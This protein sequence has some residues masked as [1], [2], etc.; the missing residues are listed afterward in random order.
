MDIF[1]DLVVSKDPQ[2]P[3]HQ[4][5]PQWGLGTVFVAPVIFPHQADGLHL[6][7][8]AISAQRFRI[9]NSWCCCTL[10]RQNIFVVGLHQASCSGSDC[11]RSCTPPSRQNLCIDI[12][13]CTML[14][15]CPGTLGH[16]G[17][18]Q[19]Q[20]LGS[21]IA[22][23]IFDL[24]VVQICFVQKGSMDCVPQMGLQC[25]TFTQSHQFGQVV[26][27]RF[28]VFDFAG[29]IIPARIFRHRPTWFHTTWEK[30]SLSESWWSGDYYI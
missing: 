25:P 8:L 26:A 21:I 1:C 13:R 16:N 20:G 2:E 5:T 10:Q 29:V 23:T 6:Q 27:W 9:W 24:H 17:P 14:A 3:V 30:E 4:V 19:M 18:W 28:D 12:W 15:Q 11:F 22:T 7:K